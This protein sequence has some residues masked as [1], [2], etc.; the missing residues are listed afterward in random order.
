MP[1]SMSSKLF[2]SSNRV[3]Y[4]GYAVC[5]WKLSE[6]YENKYLKIAIILIDSKSLIDNYFDRK[7]NLKSELIEKIRKVNN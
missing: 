3:I 1:Y 2:E 5:N 6:E 4:C 7:I